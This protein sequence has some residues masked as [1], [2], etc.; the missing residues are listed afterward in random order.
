MGTLL[1]SRTFVQDQV[2]ASSCEAEYYAYSPA[3][4]DLE[5]VRLLL[6]D[7]SLFTDDAYPPI[8]L[9][10]SEPA[11]AMSQGP[12]HRSRT[13][14]FD[15]TMALARDYIQRGRAVMEHCPTA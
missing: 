8:I 12:T 7:L 14:H 5:Y 9:V 6:R 4:K 15:F 1:L 11:M 3:V 13:K 2:S 10:D